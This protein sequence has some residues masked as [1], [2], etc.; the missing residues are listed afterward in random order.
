MS[1]KQFKAENDY[2]KDKKK[3]PKHPFQMISSGLSK[4]QADKMA[5][6]SK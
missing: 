3:K 1:K 6:H 2:S 4:A 5:K